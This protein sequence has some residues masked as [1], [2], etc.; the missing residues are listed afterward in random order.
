MTLRDLLKECNRNKV[1][2]II[3]K[4]YYQKERDYFNEIYTRYDDVWET[5]MFKEQSL[6]KEYEIYIREL[7]EDFLHDLQIDRQFGD[8][9]SV[10][11]SL[12]YQSN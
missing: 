3:Q 12:A 9:V 2:N 7:L 10:Y 1:I 11:L 8:C 5:L 6:N 4:T